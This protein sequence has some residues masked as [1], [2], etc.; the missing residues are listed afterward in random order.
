MKLSILPSQF[1]KPEKLTPYTGSRVVL[2]LWTARHVQEFKTSN[3][4]VPL[5]PTATVEQ[6]KQ[7]FVK[8]ETKTRHPWGQ[9]WAPWGHQNG[10]GDRRLEFGCHLSLAAAWTLTLSWRWLPNLAGPLPQALPTTISGLHNLSDDWWEPLP[11]AIFACVQIGPSN[12]S[13]ILGW[14]LERISILVLKISKANSMLLFG[15]MICATGA[16][17]IQSQGVWLD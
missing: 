1:P 12:C 8:R 10:E 2:S 7:M 11:I 15:F 13:S 9:A 6:K 4:N 16:M 5:L 14:W 17:D 3:K